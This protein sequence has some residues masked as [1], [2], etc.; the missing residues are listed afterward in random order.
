[1]SIH[2]KVEIIFGPSHFLLTKNRL[3]QPVQYGSHALQITAEYCSS[4]LPGSQSPSCCWL[5][6]SWLE[7]PPILLVLTTCSSE[8]AY[9][10]SLSQSRMAVSYVED[11]FQNMDDEDD[12]IDPFIGL[13]D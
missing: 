3:Y 13:E 4:L 9:H 12:S 1:M 2:K 8:I 5:D 10:E 11:L 7:L 6:Y